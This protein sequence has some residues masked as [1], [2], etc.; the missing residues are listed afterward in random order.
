MDVRSLYLMRDRPLDEHFEEHTVHGSDRMITRSLR[1]SRSSQP[2]TPRMTCLTP[3]SACHRPS[4]LH[5]FRE[6]RAFGLE[7]VPVDYPVQRD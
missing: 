1:C 3:A 5:T 2:S 6:P 4:Q 7:Q